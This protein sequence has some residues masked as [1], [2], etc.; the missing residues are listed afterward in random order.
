MKVKSVNWRNWLIAFIVI[1]VLFS[2]FGNEC[3]NMGCP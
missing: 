3:S 2:I 1:V